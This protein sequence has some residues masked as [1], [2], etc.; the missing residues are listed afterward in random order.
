MTP[1]LYGHGALQNCFLFSGI[2]CIDDLHRGTKGIIVLSFR[3]GWS[4]VHFFYIIDNVSNLSCIS[5]H[6]LIASLM[7]VYR[8][9]IKKNMKL[10]QVCG[11]MALY[12]PFQEHIL[13][14]IIITNAPYYKAWVKKLKFILGLFSETSFKSCFTP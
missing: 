7:L 12:E 11:Y 14:Q 10:D 2:T 4:T 6:L 1:L 13:I 5:F 8:D 9:L 3:I